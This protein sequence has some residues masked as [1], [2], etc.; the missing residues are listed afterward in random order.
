MPVYEFKCK[1]CDARFDTFVRSLEEAENSP[2]PGCGGKNLER[3]IS[4][5]SAP[6]PGTDSC[7]ESSKK[8]PF[9]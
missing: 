2:C 1:E 7:G 6:N 9:R 5:F 8:S 3:L 4:P